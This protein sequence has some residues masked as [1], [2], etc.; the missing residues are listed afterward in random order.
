MSCVRG[1]KGIEMTLPKT[2]RSTI[3][4]RWETL[5]RDGVN[6]ITEGFMLLGGFCP[7]RYE[8]K[9][10]AARQIAALHPGCETKTARATSVVA[11]K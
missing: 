4:E 7:Y 2:D 11:C 10:D 5:W 6:W 8:V 9:S 1:E 3:M